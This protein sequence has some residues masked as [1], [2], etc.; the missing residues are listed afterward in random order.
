MGVLWSRVISG[1]PQSGCMYTS[2]I[3][4]KV[5]FILSQLMTFVVSYFYNISPSS[6]VSFGAKSFS[7]C[8]LGDYIF[9]QC[10]NKFITVSPLPSCL[11]QP[12]FGIDGE[13]NAEQ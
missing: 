11:Y 7:L 12:L 13:A 6:K 10:L 3:D 1:L 9:A 8:C 2:T 5:F 4:A